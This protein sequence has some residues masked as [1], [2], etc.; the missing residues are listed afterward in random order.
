M[1]ISRKSDVS[2]K[3]TTR[4]LPVTP[5]Q[6]YRFEEGELVQ[7]AFPHLSAEDREWLRSGITKEEWD[8]L[9]PPEQEDNE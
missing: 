6:V 1:L 9:Y 7:K 8:E 2:G 5:E 3:I 4:D